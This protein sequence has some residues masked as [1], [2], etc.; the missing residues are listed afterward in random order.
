MTH[1]SGTKTEPCL[2]LGMSTG[3]I[4][5]FIL[6]LPVDRITSSVIVAPSGKY[7]S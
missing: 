4:T 2:W 1:F 7:Y 5:A 6:Q 3:A